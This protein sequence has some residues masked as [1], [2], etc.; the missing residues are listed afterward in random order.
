MSS[1]FSFNTS[2]ITDPINDVVTELGTIAKNVDNL[3]STVTENVLKEL[4]DLSGVPSTLTNLVNTIESI[5][6]QVTSLVKNLPSVLSKE[7]T[8]LD[9]E[10][11][12]LNLEGFAKEALNQLFSSIQRP[13]IIGGSIIA[14][15]LL[16]I[17]ILLLINLF[18]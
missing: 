15:M 5:G 2:T 11:K 7:V 16:V 3:N 9:Q 1:A 13:L 4:P 17:I 12:S 8:E 10:L 18:K 14:G 6:A